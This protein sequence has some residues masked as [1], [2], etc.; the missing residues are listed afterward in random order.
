MGSVYHQPGT[1]VDIP[2]TARRAQVINK[3]CVCSS[4]MRLSTFCGLHRDTEQG[5]HTCVHLFCEKFIAPQSRVAV[6]LSSVFVAGVGL[7]L[8]SIQQGLLQATV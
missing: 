4:T 5:G 2:V 7:G 3:P 6:P 8:A 1:E